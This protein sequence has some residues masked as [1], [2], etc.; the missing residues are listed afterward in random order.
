MTE[1]DTIRERLTAIGTSVLDLRNTGS[2]YWLVTDEREDVM[3]QHVRTA[4]FSVV[5]VIR[6]DEGLSVTIRERGV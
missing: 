5:D 6:R 3:R 2:G 4:G 1:L